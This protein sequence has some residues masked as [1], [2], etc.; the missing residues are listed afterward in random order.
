MDETPVQ[1]Y[2]DVHRCLSAAGA[3]SGAAEVHGS[4]CGMLC[5]RGKPGAPQL[6]DVDADRELA[7]MLAA[8]RERTLEHLADPDFAFTPL[9]PSDEVPLSQRVA[10]LA[11]WCGGFGYGLAAQEELDAAQWSPQVREVVQDFTAIC[12]VGLDEDDRTAEDAEQDYAELVEYVRVGAQLV[13]LELRAAAPEPAP[14][15]H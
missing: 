12:R 11:A 5:A 7:S 8:L 15:L 1:E 6:L 9:L 2:Q 4:L 14:R 10:A 3:S 13:F